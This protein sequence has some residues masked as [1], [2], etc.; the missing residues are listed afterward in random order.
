MLWGV[1]LS[2]NV[3]KLFRAKPKVHSKGSYSLP[4]TCLKSLI[5]SPAF[6]SVNLSTPARTIVQ[7]KVLPT[8]LSHIGV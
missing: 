1:S 4:L 2:I 6:T 7:V 3:L 8:S 5:S